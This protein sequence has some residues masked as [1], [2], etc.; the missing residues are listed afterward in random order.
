LIHDLGETFKNHKLQRRI[1]YE[2]MFFINGQEETDPEINELKSKLVDVAFEQKS[3]G[4][5]MPI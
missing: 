4:K 1:K 3:W 5:R 2:D